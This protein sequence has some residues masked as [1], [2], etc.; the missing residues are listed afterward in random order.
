VSNKELVFNFNNEKGHI[1]EL[2]KLAAKLAS[3]FRENPGL[4]E[5]PIVR[6]FDKQAATR[7]GEVLLAFRKAGLTSF[8]VVIEYK[9]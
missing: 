7:F 6:V 4:P 9:D 5:T 3:E 8:S 1:E 2:E